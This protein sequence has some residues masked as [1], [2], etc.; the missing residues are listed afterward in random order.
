MSNI[1]IVGDF[2]NRIKLIRTSLLLT[3]AQ[4]G[5]KIG[6]S[7]SQSS[8]IE[9]GARQLTRRVLNDIVRCYGVNAKWLCIGEGDMWQPGPLELRDS[10]AAF[11]EAYENPSWQP[12]QRK[13]EYQMA[14]PVRRSIEEAMACMFD[15]CEAE[16]FDE[17][18]RKM[19][20]DI[21]EFATE[22]AMGLAELYIKTKDSN[23]ATTVYFQNT[24]QNC[25][26]VG[27]IAEALNALLNQGKELS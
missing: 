24:N 26:D 19:A 13:T 27:A 22:Y 16:N 21:G 9:N 7:P 17:L 18:V 5:A 3:Q 11:K 6:L 2:G 20:A 1:R 25:C 8:N 23:T 10:H 12:A 14:A 15:W 4:F